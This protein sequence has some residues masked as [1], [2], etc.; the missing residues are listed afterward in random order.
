MASEQEYS[1]LFSAVMCICDVSGTWSL[2]ME[3]QCLVICTSWMYEA[4]TWTDVDTGMLEHRIIY[5]Q[6]GWLTK[7]TTC[8]HTSTIV[9]SHICNR[10]KKCFD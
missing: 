5:K 9:V 4:S 10:F 8:T 2:L 6:L 7:V 3:T 1:Y